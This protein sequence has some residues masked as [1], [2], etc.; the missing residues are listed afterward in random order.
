MRREEEWIERRLG[1]LR[2][3]AAKA[4]RIISLAD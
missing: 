3:I 2:I 4:F 1:I